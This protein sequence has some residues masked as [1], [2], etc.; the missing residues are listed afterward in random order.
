MIPRE[1]KVQGQS[2]ACLPGKQK[3]KRWKSESVKS[4]N[5]N[6]DSKKEELKLKYNNTEK[7]KTTGQRR[8]TK[9][10]LKTSKVK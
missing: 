10:G 2:T 5:Q 9:S 4:K 8:G 1:R 7:E 3:Y 6:T